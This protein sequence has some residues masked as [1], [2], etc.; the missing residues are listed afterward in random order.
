MPI[1]TQE[2]VTSPLFRSLCGMA[3]VCW[4]LIVA[5]AFYATPSTDD[6]SVAVRVA[7][8][9]GVLDAT[10]GMYLG[11]TGRWSGMFFAHLIAEH[12]EYE[13][14]YQAVVILIAFVSLGG[15]ICLVKAISGK[16]MPWRHAAMLGLIVNALFLL[17]S[18]SLDDTLYWLN[19]EICYTLGAAMAMA[20]LLGIRYA[21]ASRRPWPVR[22]ILHASLL[23][24]SLAVI[25][26]NE[27][28]G[29]YWVMVT[30]AALL[31][32]LLDR[33]EHRAIWAFYFAFS[34]IGIGVVI[35][36]PGNAVRSETLPRSLDSAQ[37]LALACKTL[38]LYLPQWFA[39]PR[40]ILATAFLLLTP[41]LENRPRWLVEATPAR[42]LLLGSFWIGGILVGTLIPSWAIGSY[43][44]KRAMTMPYLWFL[45]G[46]IGFLALYSG[47]GNREVF[48]A[49]PPLEVWA[50]AFLVFAMAT[51]GNGIRVVGELNS[52]A[53]RYQQTL[54]NLRFQTLRDAAAEGKR[55]VEVP[56]VPQVSRIL[57][58]R[59]WEFL[60][61]PAHWNNTEKAKYFGLESIAL[62][63]DEMP[64]DP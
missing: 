38:R 47:R 7:G 51:T 18:P 61:D 45:A 19:G 46:W 57:R 33:G 49:M 1:V 27:I 14:Y 5:F 25:G 15:W 13:P 31:I 40:L 35:L 17:G 12:F 6:F 37:A 10:L 48:P 52:G 63:G 59:R 3:L 30:G 50:W 32:A 39:D 11:W 4:A 26:F 29:V 34:L 64:P 22:T 42:L 43:I 62:T 16:S 2:R 23:T 36:A 41:P 58:Y 54:N 55:Q 60:P 28:L 53:A 56:Q 9:R 21:L 24:G 44:S 20:W 8:D